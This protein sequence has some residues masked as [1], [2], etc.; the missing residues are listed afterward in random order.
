MFGVCGESDVRDHLYYGLYALQHRGQTSCGAVLSDNFKLSLVR[1]HGLVSEALEPN[2]AKLNG[3]MGIGHVRYGGKKDAEEYAQPLISNYLKGNICISI[4]GKITNS[5]QLK[6]ELEDKGAIFQLSSDAEVLAHL[7]ARARKNEASVENAVLKVMP[8]LKGAYA[9]LLMSSS[10]VLAFRDKDGLRP[11]CMGRKGGTYFFSSEDCAFAAVGAEFVRDLEPGELVMVE[12][13]GVRGQVSDDEND[14]DRIK[15][16]PHSFMD[17]AVNKAKTCIYEYIYFAR[18]DS[19]IDGVSVYS[20]RVEAGKRLYKHAP[21]KADLVIGAPSAGL[22]YALGYAHESGIPYGDGLFRNY[23]LGR[24]Q[25]RD[26][27]FKQN[28]MGIKLNVIK[29]AVAGKR[30]VLVD[31]SMIRGVTA[32]RIIAL[33][34]GGEAAEVHLRVACPRFVSVCPF[35]AGIDSNLKDKSVEEIRVEVGADSLAFLPARD[36]SLIGAGSGNCKKCFMW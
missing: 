15:K 12:G 13:S 16:K 24:T 33:L 14:S 3:N 4:A 2:L 20:V 19:I 29:A 27:N 36:L 21:A 5:G 23:Y 6:A 32:K 7:I 1:G 8:H 28:A 34:R 10:K 30:I 18:P 35:S 22:H 26:E 31:D 11:L 25:G 17:Y 9:V